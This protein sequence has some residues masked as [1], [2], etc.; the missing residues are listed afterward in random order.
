MAL[1]RNQASLD[2][3]FKVK[4]FGWLG[5][6]MS[7]RF[8][9]SAKD[10]NSEFS[11][12]SMVPYV[13]VKFQVIVLGYRAKLD[14]SEPQ[15]AISCVI[16]KFQPIAFALYIKAIALNSPEFSELSLWQD[17]HLAYGGSSKTRSFTLDTKV[18]NST[19]RF[20]I[21]NAG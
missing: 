17:S 12:P 13:K 18:L 9:Y 11:L 4:S 19:K 20:Q 15:T 5:K 16:E 6:I 3:V 7:Y 2:Y 1:E 10:D 21:K 14:N 8:Q